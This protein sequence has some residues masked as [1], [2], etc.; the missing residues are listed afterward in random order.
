[1]ILTWASVVLRSPKQIIFTTETPTCAYQQAYWTPELIKRLSISYK[2]EHMSFTTLSLPLLLLSSLVLTA[3]S[4]GG[5]S[6]AKPTESAETNPSGD[7]SQSDPRGSDTADLDP[8]DVTNPDTSADLLVITQYEPGELTAADAGAVARTVIS[9][10]SRRINHRTTFDSE[11]IREA[12]PLYATGL[13]LTTDACALSG[14]SSIAIEANSQWTDSSNLLSRIYTTGDSVAFSYDECQGYLS[15]ENLE[16]Y[17]G[18]AR[19]NYLS[20]FV[21]NNDSLY[22][23]EAAIQKSYDRMS[24]LFEPL[25][26]PNYQHGDITTA[27]IEGKHD[28]TGSFYAQRVVIL[29][30]IE[31]NDDKTNDTLVEQITT[32][33]V[34]FQWTVKEDNT[35]N[36]TGNGTLS[37]NLLGSSFKMT[38]SAPLRR[39]K[40]T[41]TGWEY[42]IINSGTIKAQGTTGQL[43]IT[44]FP[45]YISYRF[46]GNNDGDFEIS[47]DRFWYEVLP[48]N[49]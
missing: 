41:N 18:A 28:L 21:S 31:D 36:L 9:A 43:E 13:Q 40:S 29:N 30:H 14:D 22:S 16:I 17:D 8:E 49:L 25:R 26:E 12:S 39:G 46:D 2:D 6:S 19:T 42:E 7:T 32:N 34:D 35:A 4:S 33:M 27:Y 44:F 3:C 23:D 48:S 38:V 45:E 5:S 24:Y 15:E 1:M 10:L 37:S 11:R 20:G 47:G